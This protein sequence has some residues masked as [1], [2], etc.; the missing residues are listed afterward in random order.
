M[1]KLSQKEERLRL[2]HAIN[3]A[4]AENKIV[5]AGSLIILGAVYYYGDLCLLVSIGRSHRHPHSSPLP[6]I[7]SRIENFEGEVIRSFFPKE[8]GEEI[9]YEPPSVANVALSQDLSESTA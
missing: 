6:L 3:Q 7:A 9:I 5:M 4:I 8:V 1:K 2:M